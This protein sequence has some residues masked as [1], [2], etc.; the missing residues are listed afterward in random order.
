M[1]F[2]YNGADLSKIIERFYFNG[3]MYT[4]EYLDGSKEEYD[5]TKE[6]QQFIK[7][8]MVLQALKR[9]K[10]MKLSNL[11]LKNCFDVFLSAICF[12]GVVLSIGKQKKEAVPFSVGGLIVSLGNVKQNMAKIR[13]LKKYKLF[14]KL[15]EDLELINQSKILKYI[16]FDNMYQTEFD[17]NTLDSYTYGEVKTI[18][19]VL[20]K[21]KGK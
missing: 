6:D 16:E 15:Y 1:N 4:V 7:R 14:F 12:S 18:N 17:I 11:K 19:K 2:T 9:D 13:E 21:V 8:I 5:L 10:E 20:K 3:N